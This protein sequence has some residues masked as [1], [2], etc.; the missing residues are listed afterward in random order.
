LSKAKHFGTFLLRRID[1]SGGSMKRNGRGSWGLKARQ[2]G[3]LIILTLS[4]CGW[5]GGQT[6]PPQLDTMQTSSTL[7][8]VGPQLGYFRSSGADEGAF[9]YGGVVRYKIGS[10]LGLEGTLGY[11]GDQVFDFGRIGGNSFSATIHTI[12]IT[13]SAMVF[14]P[15]RTTSFVPYAVGGL[16][17]YVLSIDY[18]ADINKLMGD[19]N[20][21][22]FGGHIGVGASLPLTQRIDLHAD[23]RYLFLSKIFESGAALDFSSKNYGGS[24]LTVGLLVFF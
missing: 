18:S 3:Y 6:L 7:W 2:A 12:P 8:G 21:M 19:E 14:I 15:L 17:L 4:M 20:K 11:R 23:Y 5:A 24:A 16:G 10:M 13:V 22:K 1:Y 9:Y